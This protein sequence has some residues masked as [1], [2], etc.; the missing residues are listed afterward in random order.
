MEEN[1]E[2]PFNALLSSNTSK[3]NFTLSITGKKN[4]L[5]TV[6]IIDMNG[7]NMQTMKMPSFQTIEFGDTLKEGI[8]TVEVT[9]G[10]NRITLKAI[11]VF[12]GKSR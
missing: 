10:Q 9:Q 5:A 12:G 6:R 4:E 11:K 2:I 7:R 1:N 8:D 3:G